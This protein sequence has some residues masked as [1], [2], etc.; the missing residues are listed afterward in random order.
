MGDNFLSFWDEVVH[1]MDFNTVVHFMN[2][3]HF[4]NLMINPS[5]L[6]T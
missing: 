5:T 2:I 3:I 1:F 4:V 6:W